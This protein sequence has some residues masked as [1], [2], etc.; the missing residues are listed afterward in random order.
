[1]VIEYLT[2]LHLN[3]CYISKNVDHL[4]LTVD[5]GLADPVYLCHCVFAS[6]R[7]YVKLF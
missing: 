6:K 7:K 3:I 4:T 5:S 2:P 1:M